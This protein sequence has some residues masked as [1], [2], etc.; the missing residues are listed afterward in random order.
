MTRILT[1]MFFFG[2]LLHAGPVRAGDELEGAFSIIPA[3][4]KMVKGKGVFTLGPTS[5]IL[6]DKDSPEVAAIGRYLADL[7]NRGS[8]YTIELAKNADCRKRKGTH[9]RRPLE[10]IRVDRSGEE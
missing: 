4:V 1:L 10:G 8:G 9:G 2:L 3:P 7:L 6:V 5:R